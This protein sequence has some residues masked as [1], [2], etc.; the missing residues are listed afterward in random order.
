LGWVCGF[1]L[2]PNGH[3]K[4]DLEVTK[5]KKKQKKEKEK[6]Y[7]FFLIAIQND[8]VTVQNIPFQQI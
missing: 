2:T 5:K 3:P 1:L 4:M 8:F 6:R 7:I